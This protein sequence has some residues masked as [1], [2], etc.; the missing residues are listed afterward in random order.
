MDFFKKWTPEE[1]QLFLEKMKEQKIAY[2]LENNLP[3]PA[4]DCA[5]D[6]EI[7][8]KRI[9]IKVKTSKEFLQDQNIVRITYTY[10]VPK[11][12]FIT[13]VLP[14]SC[15]SC[16]C[17][18]QTIKNKQCGRNY[19][20]QPEDWFKRPDSCKLITLDQFIEQNKSR[21]VFL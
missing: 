2:C 8:I 19:P 18:W 10:D 20:Y 4:F 16:P 3:I 14:E 7:P 21:M 15:S 17:G 9:N 6:F 11:D 13:D 12:A 1:N 5:E